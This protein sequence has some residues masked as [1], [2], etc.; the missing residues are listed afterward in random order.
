MFNFNVMDL[1]VIKYLVVC[2][3]VRNNRILN[4]LQTKF[5]EIFGK[6]EQLLSPSYVGYLT[7]LGKQK[8]EVLFFLIYI[9]YNLKQT[10]LRIMS[11]ISIYD[12]LD[13]FLSKV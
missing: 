12:E 3:C 2:K 11:K 1:L 4:L 5:V 6:A 10:V 8:L 9:S 13:F 7:P